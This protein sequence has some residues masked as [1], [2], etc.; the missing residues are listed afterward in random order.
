LTPA[1]L[2]RPSYL[3]PCKISAKS[4]NR[5]LS[6]SDLS[7]SRW[8][9]SAILDFRT[10]RDFII[11]AYTKFG[12]DILIGGVDMP[13]EWNSKKRHPGVGILLPVPTLTSVILQGPSCVSSSKSL[14]K[15]DNRRPSYNDL[16]TF[17][18]S[19]PFWVPHWAIGSQSWGDPPHPVGTM[20]Y[21]HHRYLSSFF[22]FPKNSPSSKWQGSK[23]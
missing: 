16:T 18:S 11:Y 22:R 2:R 20:G 19:G 1:I 14:A 5:L 8:P 6:N 15:W 12:E 23:D 10:L 7:N 9:P 17:T 13:P 3:S 4:D 21:A